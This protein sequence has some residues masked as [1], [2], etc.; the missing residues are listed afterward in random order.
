[1]GSGRTV[2]VA[3]SVTVIAVTGVGKLKV[4][5]QVR[6]LSAR[7]TANNVARRLS[8]FKLQ[9]PGLPTQRASHTPLV[10]AIVPLVKEHYNH[11][12]HPRLPHDIYRPFGKCKASNDS[13]LNSNSAPTRKDVGNFPFH[14]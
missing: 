2:A 7:S 13:P 14:M 1:M 11:F 12:N 6:T 8:S 4:R 10:I 3:E 5:H 9:V